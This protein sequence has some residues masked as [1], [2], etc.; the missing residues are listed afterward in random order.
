MKIVGL[1][2]GI[3]SG[4][5]TVINFLKKKKFSIH[6]SDRVVNKLYSSP[7]K[8][9]LVYLKK[10][11]FSH[12]ISKKKINK[13][14][15]REEIFKDDKKRKKIEKFIHN[16]VKR[17]RVCFLNKNKKTKTK[18][19]ILDIPLLF[20]AGLSYICDYTVLLYA[21]K[22]L[23]INRALK[24]RGMKKKILHNIIQRQLTDAHK[25]KKSNFIIDTSKTKNYCFNK[26]INILEKI[27]NNG[28]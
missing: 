1:T 8:S 23:R 2:G 12:A 26:I 15:I 13:N 28:A 21:P 22:K 16:E 3:A 25:K 17:S 7:S 19:V 4:K 10:N 11:N 24:R 6:E 14:I 27:K 5:T 20:E 18:I 9:F